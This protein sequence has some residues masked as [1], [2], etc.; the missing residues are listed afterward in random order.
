[1]EKRVLTTTAVQRYNDLKHW[2]S[3]QDGDR[4]IYTEDIL[5]YTDKKRVQ[6]DAQHLPRE[7]A[8][9]GDEIP[10]TATRKIPFGRP[11]YFHFL[12]M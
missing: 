6:W 8:E 11:H 4:E 2:I 3:T 7:T 12:E 1:M 10:H 9:A 5:S